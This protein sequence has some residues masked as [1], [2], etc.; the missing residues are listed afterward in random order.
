MLQ[1]AFIRQNPDFVKERLGV[2]NFADTDLVDI[3]ITLDDVRRKL[4]LGSDA[5]LSKINALS[6]EIGALM[7]K[8]QKQEAE[9]KKQEVA[10][11]KAALA[12]I[13]EQLIATEE[14][15][16]AALVRLPNLPAAAVPRGKT[17]EDNITIREGGTKPTLA[18]DAVPH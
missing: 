5:N 10:A 12:P 1:V 8:G 4:Q 17:P 9:D 13:A 11:A 3:V 6:K 16:N 2:R 18:K 14:Q 7:A 15:L